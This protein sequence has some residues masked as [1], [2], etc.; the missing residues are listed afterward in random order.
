MKKYLKQIIYILLMFALLLPPLTTAFASEAEEAQSA[1][2]ATNEAKKEPQINDPAGTEITPEATDAEI[3]PEAIDTETSSEATDAE[4]SPEATGAEM[5]PEATDT[6]TPPEATQKELEE[7]GEVTEPITKADKPYLALGANLSEE[8]RTV[9]LNLLGINPLELADYDVIYI[10]NEDE[11]KYLGSYISA[12]KIG[13]R[14]LSSVLVVKR[15][16]GNG[17][18][19]TTKNISYC[20]IGMYKNALITAGIIDADIIVAGPFPLSGTA[21]LVGALKAYSVMTGEEVSEKSMDAALNELVLTGDLAGHLGDS[22]KVEE[23]IAYVK[24]QI[25][26]NKLESDEEI[27]KAIEDACDEFGIT[28]TEEETRQLLQLM[29][30]ISE[31]DLDLDTIMNQAKP[32]YDKLSK[33]KDSDGFFGKIGDFFSSIIT[34]ISNFLKGLF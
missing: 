7:E 20:T 11:Y 13:K 31:L 23:L 27:Q 21:A 9:V 28:L 12:E 17:I 25:V 30:K 18:N 8:Q 15:G 14:S 32:L 24:Q 33:L 22:E 29:K 6:E 2:N 4:T 16:Q 19:I 1:D 5:N 34:A 10:T 3:T 26:E